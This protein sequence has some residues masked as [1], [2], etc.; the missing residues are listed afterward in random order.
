MGGGVR[1]KMSDGGVGGYGRRG[2][3]GEELYGLDTSLMTQVWFTACF[4]HRDKP[5]WT[6]EWPEV[7]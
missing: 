1:M 5:S 3:D 7:I 6:D 4:H 2:K